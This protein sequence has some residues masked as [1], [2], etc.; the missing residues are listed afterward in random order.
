MG[1]KTLHNNNKFN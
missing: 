1:L